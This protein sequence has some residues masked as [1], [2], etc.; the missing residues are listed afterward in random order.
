M[1]KHIQQGFSFF[2][3]HFFLFLSILFRDVKNICLTG[4][5]AEA[6]CKDLPVETNKSDNVLPQIEQNSS[7]YNNN[8]NSNNNTDIQIHLSLP[9]VNETDDEFTASE[10]NTPKTAGKEIV[11]TFS[12]RLRR[13]Q[14]VRDIIRVTSSASNRQKDI[15]NFKNKKESIILPA[16][17]LVCNNVTGKS[18][19]PENHTFKELF[20]QIPL[21]TE[22]DPLKH[23]KKPERVL[24]KLRIGKKVRLSEENSTEE[25]CDE[26]LNLRSL[27][28]RDGINSR[29]GNLCLGKT[30][31][32]GITPRDQQK[33]NKSRK[34]P[35]DS[36]L[37][38]LSRTVKNSPR[39]ATFIKILGQQKGPIP[40]VKET[41]M[42][43]AK[44][45]QS[46]VE[47]KIKPSAR[48]D[49]G[50]HLSYLRRFGRRSFHH[51]LEARSY[52]PE[53]R[54]LGTTVIPN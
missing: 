27:E 23:N 10:N 53:T 1:Q 18:Q 31:R 11:S 24:E 43:P 38:Q 8:N 26:I 44:H 54:E 12:E 42:A 50:I 15:K 5:K 51:V 7:K 34:F 21:G 6:K 47:D 14:D 4:R 30:M 16:A 45:E 39:E 41:N 22:Y 25:L 17:K 13:H 32:P 40:V 35:K 2:F 9:T 3:V 46:E 29:G 33:K 19:N 37:R 28:T 36:A 49:Y 48:K 20:P 52:K